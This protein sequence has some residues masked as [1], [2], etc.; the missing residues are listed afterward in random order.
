MV[1]AGQFTPDGIFSQVSADSEGQPS[2][3]RIA[4]E[5]ERTRK[6]KKRYV[7]ILMAHRQNIA[8]DRYDQVRY[9]VEAN[10]LDGY[11]RLFQDVDPDHGRYLRVVSVV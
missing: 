4:V 8:A 3:L 1:G 6:S 2:N 5:A 10:Y 9:Y 11:Q 7:Q